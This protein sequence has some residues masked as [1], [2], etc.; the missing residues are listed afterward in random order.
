MNGKR[1]SVDLIIDFFQ[2][3]NHFWHYCYAKSMF[4]ASFIGLI[5]SDVYVTGKY[6]KFSLNL[7]FDWECICKTS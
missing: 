6:F 4:L 1:L 5:S 2:F 3:I 7:T